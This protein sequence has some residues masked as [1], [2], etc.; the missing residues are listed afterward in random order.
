MRLKALL[1]RIFLLL[2]LLVLPYNT[3]GG[4]KRKPSYPHLRYGI[5]AKADLV[6]LRPGFALGYSHKRR[7][8]IWVS[9]QLTAEQLK[10]R[11][12]RRMNSFMADPAISMAPVQPEEYRATGFDRGHLVPAAD[13]AHDQ[14]PMRHSFFM[15][16]ISPQLPG[17]NR[18]VWKR[19]ETMTRKIAA[20]EQTILVI[21]GPLFP[22]SPQM[23]LNTDIP[24]PSGFF[25]V[26][27]DLT[28]PMKMIGFIVPNRSARNHLK[29]FVVTVDQV[30]EITG[31]DFFSRLHNNIEKPLESR[32]SDLSEWQ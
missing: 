5:P 8:A 17:C 30:E 25:K 19:I 29:S 7:Q 18:G 11:R 28:P 20:K 24:I 10:K 23:M 16:N 27:L 22:E 26:I 4:R 31:M 14:L 3:S 32:R 13:M 9:Y 2:L 21:C 6:L 1:L 12:V 15:S